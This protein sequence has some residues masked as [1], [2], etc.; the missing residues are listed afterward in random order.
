M[1]DEKL[2][3]WGKFLD[4]LIPIKT[5][6]YSLFNWSKILSSTVW[7]CFRLSEQ[8]AKIASRAY[9]VKIVNIVIIVFQEI[10]RELNGSKEISRDLKR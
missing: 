3:K 6:I 4:E 8:R 9:I 2:F 5:K 7:S 1:A 10:L